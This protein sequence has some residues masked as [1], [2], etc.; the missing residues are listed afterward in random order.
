MFDICMHYV[1]DDFLQNQWDYVLS[2]WL[3]ETLY[4]VAKEFDYTSNVFKNA[5]L[6]KDCSY[7][8]KNK[9]K[10][11]VQP[12][13]GRYVSGEKSLYDFKHPKDCIYIFGSDNGYLNE[14]TLKNV[15]LTTSVYIPTETHYDM[16]SPVAAAIVLYD[17]FCK[18]GKSN[19]R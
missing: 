12:E 3:C 6:I 19:N 9:K 13:N 18:N 1:R 10:V 2:H 15:K 7:L 5:K 17:R 8:P 11:L 14:D 4:C 16:Y